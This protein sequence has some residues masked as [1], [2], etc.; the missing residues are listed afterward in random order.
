MAFSLSTRHTQ[1]SLRAACR[2]LRS[3]AARISSIERWAPPDDTFDIH[4]LNNTDRYVGNVIRNMTEWGDEVAAE[5]C[6]AAGLPLVVAGDGPLLDVLRAGH[7]E[8]RFAGRVGADELADLRARAAL[9]LVPSRAAETFGLVA[10]EAMAAGVP[11]VV[12]AIG[13]LPELAA[14]TVEPGDA[15]ALAAAARSAH[16]DEALGSEGL[17]RVRERCA[18]EVVAE[19]LAAVYG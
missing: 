12:S 2:R 19:R 7:P 14:R 11:V 16:G 13:A 3:S 18:P 17:A 10:A 8:V 6:E 15:A 5:A 1:T 9:A 4:G